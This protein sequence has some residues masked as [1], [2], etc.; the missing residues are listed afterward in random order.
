[1][2]PETSITKQESQLMRPERTRD[3]WSYTPSVDIIEMENELFVLADMPGV[4]TK[5]VDVRYEQ[6]LLTIH[7][8]VEPRQDEVSTNYLLCEYG[9]GDYYRTFQIGEG[10]DASKISAEFRNGVLELH[11]P[12]TQAYKPRKIVVKGP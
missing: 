7:G 8:R 11:L 12:K 3:V 2:N 1:M 5:D 9:I 10:I 6:G 4:E